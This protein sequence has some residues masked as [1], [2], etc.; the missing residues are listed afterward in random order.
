MVFFC[1]PNTNILNDDIILLGNDKY[2][3]FDCGQA[4]YLNVANASYFQSV[5]WGST[6]W[7]NHL[8]ARMIAIKI[9]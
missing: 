5:W 1:L 3:V 8:P 7:S 6:A 9:S 4:S 2:Q